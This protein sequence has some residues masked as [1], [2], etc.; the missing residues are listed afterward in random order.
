[1]LA[2]VG[3]GD[4]V[5]FVWKSDSNNGTWE[6]EDGNFMYEGEVSDGSGLYVASGHSCWGILLSPGTGKALASKMFGNDEHKD[7]LKGLEPT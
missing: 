7:C 6:T 2:Q 4:R 3:N 1:M 5:K